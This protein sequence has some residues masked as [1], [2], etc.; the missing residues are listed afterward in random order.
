MA[1][2]KY[3]V[4]AS[5]LNS[6]KFA[7]LSHS[8]QALYPQILV[9]TDTN[10]GTS[11]VGRTMRMG[12]FDKSDLQE[13]EDAGLVFPVESDDGPVW[14]IADYFVH[15]KVK[16]ESLENGEH[17]CLACD[18]LAV[19]LKTRRLWPLEDLIEDQDEPRLADGW[20][21]YLEGLA[22][23]KAK[24]DTASK[25]RNA[26]PLSYTSP[27]RAEENLPEALGWNTDEAFGAAYLEDTGH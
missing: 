13:L 6:D 15:N 16:T 9:T 12:G 11:G 14:F 17:Y 3:M 26:N 24:R 5:V 2:S 18:S 20:E 21:S 27:E 25:K 7:A 23:L 19:S 4:S 1:R 22:T 8:A 10:G